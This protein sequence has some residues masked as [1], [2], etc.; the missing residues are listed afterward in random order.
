MARKLKLDPESLAVESFESGVAVTEPGTV[1]A[2]DKVPCV[3]S[4]AIRFS[5]PI[6]WDGCVAGEFGAAV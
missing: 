4:G 6:S 3:V 5:C 1:E 2:Y